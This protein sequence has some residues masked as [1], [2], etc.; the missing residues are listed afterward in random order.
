M[1]LEVSPDA[2]RVVLVPLVVI[3]VVILIGIPVMPVKVFVAVARPVQVTKLISANGSALVDPMV[4]QVQGMHVT[5]VLLIPVQYTV[6]V[7]SVHCL[8]VQ[9]VQVP[10]MT[11]KGQV[12]VA[13][14]PSNLKPMVLVI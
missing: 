10:I 5:D 6:I 12:A 9:A 1:G 8:E 2:V 4:V 14:A 11:L 13:V 7:R 3:S